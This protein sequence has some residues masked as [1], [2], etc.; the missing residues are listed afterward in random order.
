[1]VEHLSRCE[2]DEAEAESLG[3]AAQSV[4][5]TGA[6]ELLIGGRARVVVDDVAAQDPVNQHRNFAGG[7]G[8][9]LGWPSR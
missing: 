1:M 9:A 7:G 4:D 8:I 2:I 5:D 6:V 3:A